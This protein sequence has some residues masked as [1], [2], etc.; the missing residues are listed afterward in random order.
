M[1]YLDHVSGSGVVSEVLAG[2]AQAL[3]NH[4]L[5]LLSNTDGCVVSPE[6]SDA[7][8]Y[9]SQHGSEAD[10]LTWVE[11]AGTQLGLQLRKV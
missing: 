3:A 10:V 2:R 5:F 11:E 7:Y 9:A 4:V 6:L 1:H 8:V